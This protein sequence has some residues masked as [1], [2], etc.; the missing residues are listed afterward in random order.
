[1][2]STTT[3]SHT[4]L[5]GA[6][7]VI[8][9]EGETS[10]VQ[11]NISRSQEH[12][13][14][15]SPICGLPSEILGIIFSMLV[16][17]MAPRRNTE[18][19]HSFGAHWIGLTAVCRRW[20]DIALRTPCM[21]SYVVLTPED[22]ETITAFIQRSGQV[23]LTLMHQMED[24]SSLPVSVMR[25]IL[26]QFHRIR[27]LSVNFDMPLV[28]LLD[29]SSTTLDGPILDTLIIA[30]SIPYDMTSFPAIQ[31]AS[32][33]R[34]SSLHCIYVSIHLLRALLRP[35]LTSLTVIGH[36]VEQSV[37]TWVEIIRELPSLVH[38]SLE[39]VMSEPNVLVRN[40]PEPTR[41]VLL[42]RLQELSLCDSGSGVACATFLNHLII[43]ADAVRSFDSYSYFWPG[44]QNHLQ[45]ILSACASKTLGESVIGKPSPIRAL[46]FEDISVRSTGAPL[47]LRIYNE[48]V[49]V[50]NANL[51]HSPAGKL[52]LN[53]SEHI[54]LLCR[55]DH[56]LE[57][58]IAEYPLKN[59]SGIYLHK[60]T[61]AHAGVWTM[62]SNL[63]N[64]RNLYVGHCA[65]S[66]TGLL[67]FLREDA[68]FPK[69]ERL[70]LAG[71]ENKHIYR[72]GGY[73][74]D[75]LLPLLVLVLRARSTHGHTLKELQL[76]FVISPGDRCHCRLELQGLEDLTEKFHSNLEVTEDC[77]ICGDLRARVGR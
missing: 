75:T 24:P 77:S 45:F 67:E 5:E 60:A 65:T 57:T 56:F 33:P 20:R 36:P 70:Q 8:E 11:D 68:S 37:A 22:L 61:I 12:E 58:F 53:P 38:L 1:M 46:S 42:P 2:A 30:G 29:A 28:E 51:V 48:D 6:G 31:N 54:S 64:V 63:P 39:D 49:F 19:S 59:V 25:V 66:I 73:Y 15:F 69:L 55:Q 7:S 9:A 76:S 34:L 52:G 41:K 72:H 50:N 3:L 27:G 21:W 10:K 43:P 35:N 16:S 4:T 47:S 40:I 62:L 74:K 44:D 32:W 14:W 18:T 13:T 23:P 26:P 17:E 71:I